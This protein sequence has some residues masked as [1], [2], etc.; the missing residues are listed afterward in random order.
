M[1]KRP[2]D[3]RIHSTV[4]LVYAAL[5]RK[6]DALR[7]G[8][9]A[10]E[11]YPVSKDALLG[12]AYVNTYAEILVRV[13]EYE[14]ALEKIEYLLSIPQANISVPTLQN[15]PQWEPLRNHPRFKQ[16]IEKYLK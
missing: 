10:M 11:M 1:K 9:L 14:E 12:P 7:E 16:I 2:Q 8:K 13:G 4:G 5:G 3:H 15:D 6:E